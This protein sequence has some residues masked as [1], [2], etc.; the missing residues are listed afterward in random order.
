M[1]ILKGILTDQ[2]F[3]MRE[4]ALRLRKSRAPNKAIAAWIEDDRLINEAGKALVIIMNSRGCDWALGEG[5]GCSMCGYHNDSDSAISPE[6]ISKQLDELGDIKGET[7]KI[8]TS[9]SFPDPQEISLSEQSSILEIFASKGFTRVVVESRPEFVTDEALET[10]TST[11]LEHVE[12]AFGLETSDDNIRK[13]C[14]QKGFTFDEYERATKLA[15]NK[16]VGIRTYLL[17]KPPYI[18]ESAAMEDLARSLEVAAPHTDTFS[19]NPMNIQRGTL[20]EKLFNKGF[21]R[22]PWYWSL[23]S[24][25]ENAGD[26]EIVSFPSGGSLLRGIH[27]CRNC[28]QQMASAL[29]KYNISKD[30]SVFKEL[31]C[32][33]KEEWKT[34]L[35][36]EN[37]SLNV[38][39]NYRLKSRQ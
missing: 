2:L 34:L 1:T 31:E 25:L 5:G 14:I 32:E 6:T 26:V 13:K 11:S 38:S 19:I 21:Y 28:D 22:P 9:G 39:M 10:L 4:K 24:V 30:P 29:D 8:Y 12:I 7:A 15:R 37:N 20:L 35:H 18:T 23:F 16:G 3:T 17:F 36:A 27:N 33:C